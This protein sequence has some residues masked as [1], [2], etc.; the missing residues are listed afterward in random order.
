MTCKF[1]TP[2]DTAYVDNVYSNRCAKFSPVT[3]ILALQQGLDLVFHWW[4]L[5]AIRGGDPALC[6][7]TRKMLILF[8]FSS[9]E[10]LWWHKVVAKLCHCGMWQKT[11]DRIARS[12]QYSRS[13]LVSSQV[14]SCI[15]RA[16]VPQGILR[17]AMQQLMA[18]QKARWGGTARAD[19]E[20]A[21][22]ISWHHEFCSCRE[23][24][25]PAT[26]KA[27]L[28]FSVLQ[29]SFVMWLTILPIV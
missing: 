17:I 5:S 14:S 19:S 16:G 24:L 18:L 9:L 26:G 10:N 3:S 12:L 7:V 4:L 27:W 11:N 8:Y 20:V 15:C 21:V 6:I 1:W 13:K 28:M 25:E 2:K 22:I 23:E 29:M